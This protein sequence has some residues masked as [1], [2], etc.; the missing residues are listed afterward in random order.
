MSCNISVS[1]F[2]IT[3]KRPALICV[4]EG[5]S[6]DHDNEGHS[7]TERCSIESFAWIIHREI[8]TVYK[9]WRAVS[10]IG[11]NERISDVNNSARHYLLF[12]DILLFILRQIASQGAKIRPPIWRRINIMHDT[13]RCIL[14]CS[15]C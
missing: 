6:S 13:K 8:C 5:L 11:T 4:F 15:S 14:S 10:D 2:N 1:S 3:T 12:I 7:S 9:T